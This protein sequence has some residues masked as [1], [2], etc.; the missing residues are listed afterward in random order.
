MVARAL[1]DLPG[2][3]LRVGHPREERRVARPKRVGFLIPRDCGRGVVQ[4]HRQV[5]NPRRT[6]RLVAI[7]ID[8]NRVFDERLPRLVQMSQALCDGR[9]MRQHIRID[10]EALRRFPENRLCLCMPACQHQARARTYRA[11]RCWPSVAMAA[12][13]SASS[14][15][16]RSLGSPRSSAASS[17]TWPSAA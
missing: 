6:H 2:A 13:A 16:R 11:S 8:E 15:L 1:L 12:G 7:L 4:L 9:E 14:A 17:H 5:R 3:R 10:G